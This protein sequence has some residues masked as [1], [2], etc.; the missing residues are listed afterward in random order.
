MAHSLATLCNTRS[1]LLLTQISHTTVNASST[2][3]HTTF[4][5]VQ[6]AGLG[7]LVKTKVYNLPVHE[8]KN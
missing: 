5:D 3:K 8:K 2:A 1:P 7:S 4:Q 6:P